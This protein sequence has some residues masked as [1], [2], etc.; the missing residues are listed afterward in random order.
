MSTDD[1]SRPSSYVAPT[2]S[3]VS[4]RKKPE[5]F[6]FSKAHRAN[7]SSSVAS[8][9]SAPP[10]GKYKNLK[11]FAPSGSQ[12]RDLTQL[13]RDHALKRH[14]SD[15]NGNKGDGSGRPIT[16]N[17]SGSKE[18]QQP[19][20]SHTGS[21]DDTILVDNSQQKLPDTAL[22]PSSMHS[23][24][25]GGRFHELFTLPA[26][27]ADAVLETSTT[28]SSFLQEHASQSSDEAEEDDDA[29]DEP[30]Q[31]DVTSADDDEQ[32]E[33]FLVETLPP[34]RLHE[35]FQ[36]PSLDEEQQNPAEDNDV[37]ENGVIL[38]GTASAG[39]NDSSSSSENIAGASTASV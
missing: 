29:L 33:D 19:T 23:M 16:S 22:S 27:S 31:E 5:S 32:E 7:G 34:R 9:K 21:D 11:D 20:K 12:R 39:D 30:S 13:G 18:D 6:T 1:E 36:L 15:S 10:V 28:V 14:R 3:D 4:A 35:M 37:S 2:I 38:E 25:S 24:P 17:N 8:A 26:L